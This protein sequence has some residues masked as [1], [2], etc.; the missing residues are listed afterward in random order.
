VQLEALVDGLSFDSIDEAE[1]SWLEREFEKREVLKVVKAMNGDNTPGPNGYFMV[2]FQA[3][4]A[5]LKEDTMKV[6]F[7]FHSSDKFERRKPPQQ[8]ALSDRH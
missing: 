3:C 1:A 8:K 4:W 6:F 7:E 2:F 5:V